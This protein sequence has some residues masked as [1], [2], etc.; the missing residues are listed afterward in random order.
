MRRTVKSFNNFNMVNV[1][2]L[3][4]VAAR[5]VIESAAEKLLRVKVN[6]QTVEGASHNTKDSPW[7]R[8]YTIAFAVDRLCEVGDEG[9]ARIQPGDSRGREQ[10]L[11]VVSDSTTIFIV[12]GAGL[13]CDA[14][15]EWRFEPMVNSG[16]ILGDAFPTDYKLPIEHREAVRM[17]FKYARGR[18]VFT[19]SLEVPV[20]NMMATTSA[21]CVQAEATLGRLSA[22][23][24]QILMD[25]FPQAEIQQAA[26]DCPDPWESSYIPPPQAPATGEMAT[27]N[28]VM[29]AMPYRT[30][31]NLSIAGIKKIMEAEKVIQDLIG[32]DW[33]DDADISDMCGVYDE[34]FGAR[35]AEGMM[36]INKA[37]IPR[38]HLKQPPKW[39]EKPGKDKRSE[40]IDRGVWPLW[41]AATHGHS[42]K[43]SSVVD[44]NDIA[45]SWY[46]NMSRS[47]LGDIA[48][49]QGTPILARGHQAS[50]KYHNYFAKEI[51]IDAP[52]V[53]G[54]SPSPECVIPDASEDECVEVEVEGEDEPPAPLSGGQDPAEDVD[55]EVDEA[56][57]LQ[58]QMIMDAEEVPETP[59]PIATGGTPTI[60]MTAEDA[61]I[62]S[63]EIPV[64]SIPPQPV[65]TPLA[66]P[67]PSTGG[68]RRCGASIIKASST[69][70]GAR[71]RI[72]SEARRKLKNISSAIAEAT[73]LAEERA[74]QQGDIS[75]VEI[76]AVRSWELLRQVSHAIVTC[77][78]ETLF[79]RRAVK[80]LTD[81]FEERGSLEISVEARQYEVQRL[82]TVCEALSSVPDPVANDEQTR[83]RSKR[84]QQL[85]SQ[86]REVAQ[87]LD[88]ESLGDSINEVERMK[89]RLQELHSEFQHL[90]DSG[91]AMEV[92][93]EAL[94]SVRSVLDIAEAE[95]L[96]M[97]AEK[98]QL[99]E[100]KRDMWRDVL[101][102]LPTLQESDRGDT[103]GD[104]FTRAAKP[105]VPPAGTEFTEAESWQHFISLS[106]RILSTG[107]G[108][109]VRFD[110][111][112]LYK[113]L[114]SANSAGVSPW[115]SLALTKSEA[116]AFP[117]AATEALVGEFPFEDWHPVPLPPVP[118]PEAM[119]DERRVFRQTVMANKLHAKKGKKSAN[120]RCISSIRMRQAGGGSVEAVVSWR[121]R[122]GFRA[123][124][125]LPRLPDFQSKLVHIEHGKKS[126][127]CV[128]CL[129]AAGQAATDP[130]VHSI[131]SSLSADLRASGVRGK[132]A[133]QRHRFQWSVQA[134]GGDFLRL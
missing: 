129:M 133:A 87:R 110:G 76:K 6:Q 107:R 122:H 72:F 69:T 50:G 92:M 30:P 4:Q 7:P 102:L 58:Q 62:I 100:K 15:G 128:D 18:D 83:T 37:D 43:I 90:D 117:E 114:H 13:C 51:T 40:H 24:A 84:R 28:E 23:D 55:V 126:C 27:F 16:Q 74:K 103:A 93:G 132:Y 88:A 19:G 123:D 61:A 39:L 26:E 96:A 70:G 2:T 112:P 127:I 36:I 95:R 131:S 52:I 101:N 48:A 63:G 42:N 33:G 45:T 10:G 64:T 104:E 41:I 44:D 115:C 21:R 20:A 119:E 65:T 17:F 98:F 5:P 113:E 94:K 54:P 34:D 71:R 38:E 99:Q 35:D 59:P 57:S 108:S 79:A 121:M 25:N 89:E 1:D 31:D 9:L 29:T 116:P 109:V 46:M 60:E 86:V 12:L 47:D 67:A 53:S 77:S 78:R 32:Y 97:P 81:N 56:P 118:S 85:L 66:L 134:E 130:L 82:Q 8:T 22:E 120:R 14:T 111:V 105:T 80:A 3:E 49:F 73:A 91:V 68:R 125:A 106:K 11:I 124:R 75:A